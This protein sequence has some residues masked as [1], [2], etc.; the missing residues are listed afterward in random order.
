MFKQFGARRLSS[1][2][3]RRPGFSFIPRSLG[4]TMIELM[5]VAAILGVLA[6]LGVFA[7]TTQ[8]K[9]G[10]DA[11][12]QGDIQ[13]MQAALEQRMSIEGSYVDATLKNC[14]ALKAP[15]ADYFSGEFAFAGPQ[16][17]SYYC[18]VNPSDFCL[19][20]KL[21]DT[22]RANSITSDCSSLPTTSTT[23]LFFCLQN[24]Q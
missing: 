23:K 15:L 4:F 17:E 10:R 12:R 3:A 9:R 21:E 24:Q 20:A 8:L 2:F 14:S 22:R 11:K 18:T 5:I 6:T 1:L 19:C 7:T 13:A 16:N